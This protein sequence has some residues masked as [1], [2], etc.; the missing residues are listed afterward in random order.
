[1][2]E[3]FDFLLCCLA[4]ALNGQEWPGE[5][6]PL[7]PDLLTVARRQSVAGLLADAPLR[8]LRQFGREERLRLVAEAL[9]QQR[10]HLMTNAV[11]SDIAALFE[12]EHVQY[13]LLKGQN[14][15]RCYPVPE[16]RAIG[17]IDLYVAPDDFQR[18]VRLFLVAGY[19]V[20]ER[21]WLHTTLRNPAG[22]LVELHHTLQR[23]QWPRHNTVL[24]QLCAD[25]RFN[26]HITLN[27]RRVSVLPPELDMILLTLHPLTH[28]MGEGIGLR[29]VCDWIMRLT[30]AR[31]Q[32]QIDNKLMQDLLRRL[33]LL[34]MWRA[35]ACIAA[36]RLNM[37]VAYAQLVSGCAARV[38]FTRRESQWANLILRRIQTTG[39]F[40][41]NLN[42]P[43]CGCRLM[44]RYSLFVANSFRFTTMVPLEALSTPFAKAVEGIYHRLK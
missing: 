12:R 17:D 18:A 11:L 33:H 36:T 14:C 1:M 30:R 40:G 20:V 10:V 4:A 29:H 32:G 2:T 34:N 15:A 6:T 5:G 21:T 23:M 8:L 13:C 24:K 38:D 43:E 7:P 26:H 31:E 25:I 41:A 16:R 42:L 44:G 39:N 3:T 22:T 37:P 35:L 9:Y 27:N 28:L 19:A